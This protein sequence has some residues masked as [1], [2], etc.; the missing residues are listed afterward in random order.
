[1]AGTVACLHFA[2]APASLF[3]PDPALRVSGARSAGRLAIRSTMRRTA[4]WPPFSPGAANAW[5]LM[6]TAKP[7]TW[8][9]PMMTWPDEGPAL[10]R[11][12]P[13]FFYPDP[14]GFWTEI[15]RWVAV[16]VR[17][18]VPALSTSD[19]LSVAAVIHAGED[20]DRVR[21]AVECCAP[22][23]ILFLDEASRET[24]GVTA[25]ATISIPDPHREGTTYDGWW[26]RSADGI[27]WGKAPQHP[28]SHRF[29]RA[30]DMDAYL[31]ATPL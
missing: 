10:G 27:I 29:Y 30:Q 18:A 17:T 25:G 22:R 19:A 1:M 8:R 20:A 4:G 9:D 13:G 7:P 6:V 11:P 21:W 16:L 5:L 2:I 28:A 15:R 14:L 24:A 31:H 23:I 12:H 3:D 26:L